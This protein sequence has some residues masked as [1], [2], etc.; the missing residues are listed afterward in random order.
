M[1]AFSFTVRA[2]GAAVGGAVVGAEE[3]VDVN[4]GPGWVSIYADPL[5]NR[6]ESIYI[7]GVG[8]RGLGFLDSACRSRSNGRPPGLLF[9]NARN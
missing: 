4:G 8:I 1:R 3:V 5:K 2:G 6:E 9:C 7:A